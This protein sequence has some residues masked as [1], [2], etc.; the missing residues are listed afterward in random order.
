MALVLRAKVGDTFYLNDYPILVSK[1][2]ST[3]CIEIVHGDEAV[4]VVKGDWSTISYDGGEVQVNMANPT[5][6]GMVSIAFKAPLNIKILR[7]EL[8]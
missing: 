4:T 2:Y 8:K 7:G 3:E 1:V 5:L 6:S